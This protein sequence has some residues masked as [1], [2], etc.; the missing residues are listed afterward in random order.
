MLEPIKQQAGKKV[1]GKWSKVAKVKV[2]M[3]KDLVRQKR[4]IHSESIKKSIVNI[5]DWFFAYMCILCNH[6]GW[7]GI[8]YYAWNENIGI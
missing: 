6:K 3:W 4:I 8:D 2:R 5:Y 1:Y 7:K